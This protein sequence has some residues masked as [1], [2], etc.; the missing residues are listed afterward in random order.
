MESV[1]VCGIILRSNAESNMKISLSLH[2]LPENIKFISQ[3]KFVPKYK[4]PIDFVMDF[5]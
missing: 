4:A 3:L 1:L 2:N 5:L